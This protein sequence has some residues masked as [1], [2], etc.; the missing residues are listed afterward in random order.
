MQN[1]GREGFATQEKMA[2][3]S[4]SD[5]SIHIGIPKTSTYSEKRIPLTPESVEL[6]SARGHRV[7]IEAGAGLASQHTDNDYS[8]A[9]A[10]IVYDHKEVY[11]ADVILKMSPITMDEVE[12]LSK[13]KKIFSPLHLPQL[14]APVIQ[15]LLNKQDCSCLK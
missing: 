14:K 3:L 15:E 6:L 8:E 5:K 13:G 10:K 4:T 9:G 1:L 12:F 7:W 11:S 2:K